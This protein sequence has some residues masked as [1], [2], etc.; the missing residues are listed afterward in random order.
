M[1]PDAQLAMDISV[2]DYRVLWQDIK[3]KS[4]NAL[5]QAAESGGTVEVESVAHIPRIVDMNCLW[6][7]SDEEIEGAVER[8]FVHHE[9]YDILLALK[10]RAKLFTDILCWVT[11]FHLFFLMKNIGKIGAG[12]R[13]GSIIGITTQLIG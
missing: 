9:L 11:S 7:M 2:K 1:D 4:S 12:T 6:G 10:S 5:R 3:E 8:H 13:E